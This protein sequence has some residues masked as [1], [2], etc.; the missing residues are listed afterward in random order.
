[1]SSSTTNLNL[2]K[3][4]GS[5]YVSLS[6]IN[7]NY[8][9]I[10]EF[11]GSVVG[12]EANGQGT[13][14]ADL[15]KLKV[16]NSIYNVNKATWNQLVGT[17][18]KIAE[19]TVDGVPQDVYIP[20]DEG[21][22]VVWNQIIQQGTKIATITINSTPYDI[23][24]PTAGA[25]PELV[26]LNDVQ[27]TDLADGQILQYDSTEQKWVNVTGGT[28]VEAN[29]SGTATV[30]LEKLQVNGVV[31]AIPTP[32][33]EDLGNV[34]FTNITNNQVLMYDST[35]Q[36]WINGTV[37]GGATALTGLDDVTI[38]SATNGQ[39]LT[40]DSTS[41]KWV[42]AN[43]SS[44]SATFSGLTDV[45]ISNVQNGQVPKWNS[46]T[47]K[48]ENANESGGG[49]TVVA[50]PSG[51]ATAD[52]TKLQV[53]NDIY[54]IPSGGGGGGD[55]YSKTNIYT[56][57]ATETT[58]SLSQNITDFDLIEFVGWYTY[59]D[60]DYTENA[61]YSAS[62]LVDNIGTAKAFGL[63]NDAY[64]TYYKVNDVDE[65]ECVANNNGFY[66][67]QVNG[68]KVGGGGSE[69]GASWD[70]IQ[71]TLVAGQT[72]I[73][74]SSPKIKA[75]SIIDVYTDGGVDYND[76]TASVGSVTITYDA[77]QTDLGVLVSVRKPNIPRTFDI[78][79]ADF[80]EN[81]IWGA[82]DP[83]YTT[84][85]DTDDGIRVRGGETA[86]NWTTNGAVCI[87]LNEFTVPS[88][89]SAIQ[90][91]FTE[92]TLVDYAA[93][94]IINS[95]TLW[96]GSMGG[97][98]AMLMANG[99]YQLEDIS[100]ISASDYDLTVPC[101]SLTGRYLYIMLM[102]GAI[103]NTT[104]GYSNAYNGSFDGTV[105]GINFVTGGNS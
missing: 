20:D 31:Y 83:T 1:M 99:I 5:E 62:D 101:N 14:T 55:G 69:G 12:V 21:D 54:A 40:Y 9:K 97:S 67:K 104:S 26:N 47:S 103:P 98:D 57:S 8:D 36:K 51:T 50:N 49:T 84:V 63:Y 102:D 105:D 60:V 46:T 81:K 96:S 53:G 95:D 68:I 16:G 77:Q 64:F 85:S 2:T 43:A 45:D 28:D 73:T 66:I 29:P 75:N 70:D 92:L 48:W 17:G 35:L 23:Y 80:I 65:L 88:G 58:I 30:D 37:T 59:G 94:R 19:I 11:A 38:S 15:T 89:L 7:S 39:V 27:V 22:T 18:T 90:F 56:A 87:D 79:L 100:G 71:G 44:G 32:N 82:Y 78:S 41:N 74:I 33:V 42:N 52:L 4:T 34:E 86:G 25:T 91:H 24:A 10:D 13:A 61:I 6:V 93:V 76:L 3:P 72:S